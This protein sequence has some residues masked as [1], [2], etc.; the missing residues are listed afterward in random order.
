MLFTSEVGWGGPPHPLCENI[1]NHVNRKR[2]ELNRR[3]THI[4]IFWEAIPAAKWRWKA[5]WMRMCC[6][7]G[8]FLPLLLCFFIILFHF[9]HSARSFIAFTKVH[10][11][12]KEPNDPFIQVGLKFYDGIKL[13]YFE[14]DV[15]CAHFLII[16]IK[17]RPTNSQYIYMINKLNDK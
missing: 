9:E 8:N 1:K 10:G 15:P 7:E 5:M 16:M 13:H 3:D 2:I 4:Y 6:R 12:I 17:N 11:D 14:F